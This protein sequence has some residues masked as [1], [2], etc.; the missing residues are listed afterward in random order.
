MQVQANILA[1]LGSDTAALSALRCLKLY[2]ERIG[3]EAAAPH[4]VGAGRG[5]GW[6]GCGAG[7]FCSAR[8]PNGT[9]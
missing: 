8:H 9:V 5:L 2:L 1:A 6:L 4:K 3:A 7:G